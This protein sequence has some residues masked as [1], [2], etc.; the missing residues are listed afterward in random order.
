MTN[1]TSS[2]PNRQQRGDIFG[3]ESNHAEPTS[4]N[5]RDHNNVGLALSSQRRWPE[6]IV[7]FEHAIAMLDELSVKVPIDNEGLEAQS[8][9]CANLAQAHFQA[10]YVRE[11]LPYAER[12]CAIRVSLFGEDTLSVA[13]ARADWA[14][15]L[16]ANGQF[17][18]AL[19][20]LNRAIASVELKLGDGS[21]LLVSM[22]LENAS[23]LLLSA[24]QASDAH[25]YALRMLSLLRSLNENTAPAE[26]LL[27]MIAN[28]RSNNQGTPSVVPAHTFGDADVANAS[29]DI[30]LREAIA[31]TDELLRSTPPNNVAVRENADLMD[32]LPNVVLSYAET[33]NEFPEDASHNFDGIA[34]GTGLIDSLDLKD[35]LDV[36]LHHALLAAAKPEHIVDDAAFDLVEPPPPTLNSLPEKQ[37]SQARGNPLG[38]EVQYGLTPNTVGEEALEERPP[39]AKIVHITENVPAIR[40]G[41]RAV[42]GVR[43]GRTQLVEP[44]RIWYVVVIAVTAFITA[45]GVT[46]WVLPLLLQ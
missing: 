35:E 33:V 30:M 10:G 38:F 14:V 28:V 32:S 2:V 19:S 21:G 23:R 46:V 15:V 39:I 43:S 4:E 24:N 40:S 16:G 17:D 20:L 9:V 11:A 34:Q 31:E 22:L 45:I 1:T 37:S 42:G 25:R 12:S 8:Q 36:E 41:V 6:A 44:K 7:A 13:R 26:Q 5:W 27:V 29:D 18:H 3:M